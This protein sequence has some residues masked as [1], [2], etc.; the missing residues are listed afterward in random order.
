[1][2][3]VTAAAKKNFSQMRHVTYLKITCFEIII[4]TYCFCNF[5]MIGLKESL[6]KFTIPNMLFETK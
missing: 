1:M 3:P 5:K 4:Q 2:N 6:A